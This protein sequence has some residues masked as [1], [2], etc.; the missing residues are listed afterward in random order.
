MIE[1]LCGG[2]RMLRTVAITTSL[3]KITLLSKLHTEIISITQ[4][5]Y[6][7][8]FISCIEM[9]EQNV[10]QKRQSK[11]QKKKKEALPKKN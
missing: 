7:L 8:N 3:G 11:N 10:S 9:S 1:T 6:T 2:F 4:G 5:G